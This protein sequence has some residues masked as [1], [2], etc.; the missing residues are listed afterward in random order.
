MNKG[1]AVITS[2]DENISLSEN[3]CKAD[4]EGLHTI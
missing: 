2:I 1:K 4:Y 3:V